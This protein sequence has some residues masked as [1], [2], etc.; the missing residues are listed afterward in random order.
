MNDSR[1][2]RLSPPNVVS[3]ALMQQC[4]A[5]SDSLTLAKP[6][7]S[8]L[9]DLNPRDMIDVQ[10]FLWVQGSDEYEEWR[11]CRSPW[12]GTSLA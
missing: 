2:F 12:P 7:R 3:C 1:S 6:V 4:K 9:A 5:R 8:N 10:S 11:S